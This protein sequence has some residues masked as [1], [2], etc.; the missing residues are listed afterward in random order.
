MPAKKSD[1]SIKDPA[2]VKLDTESIE[3]LREFGIEATIKAG[4]S[5]TGLIKTNSGGGPKL[6]VA[7]V[8]T[9][10]LGTWKSFQPEH[11]ITISIGVSGR[12]GGEINGRPYES[13]QEGINFI[14]MPNETQTSKIHSEETC[15]WLLNFSCEHFYKEGMSLLQRDDNIIQFVDAIQGH[16]AFLEAGARHLLWLKSSKPMHWHAASKEATKAAMISFV[17]ARM[18]GSLYQE[19][20]TQLKGSWSS[21]V[22]ATIS[23]ME[24]FYN[25]PLTLG[26]LCNVCHVSART[27]QAAFNE[28]R[29]ETPMLALRRTRLN[30]LRLLL[31]EGED[32]AT[33]CSKVGLSPTGRTAFLYASEF[34]E[35]PNQTSARYRSLPKA[36]NLLVV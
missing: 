3:S 29:K 6:D 1:T 14:S 26:D 32:V 18:S 31:I 33:S 5:D 13:K 30:K 12:Y 22:D 16:E 8:Y 35:K 4:A 2:L 19:E 11:K 27:L 25:L 23:F 10:N 24:E 9:R 20:S 17:A 21:Y 28:I 34:G 15:G 7:R 36:G